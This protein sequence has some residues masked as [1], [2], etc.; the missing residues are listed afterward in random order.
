[1]SFV[2]D[3]AWELSNTPG[4]IGTASLP[5][6]VSS[7]CSDRNVFQRASD[8]A[9]RL[10]VEAGFRERLQRDELGLDT[11]TRGRLTRAGKR[12][13][14]LRIEEHIRTETSRDTIARGRATLG[15]ARLSFEFTSDDKNATF[16]LKGSC[17]SSCA[18]AP[19]LLVRVDAKRGQCTDERSRAGSKVRINLAALEIL[20]AKIS[21]GLAPL[22]LCHLLVGYLPEMHDEEW[23]IPERLTDAITCPPKTVVGSQWWRRHWWRRVTGEARRRR[24]K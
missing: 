11:A 10:A 5:A 13:A 4:V 21:S 12:L 7:D 18:H 1:M 3:L 6:L 14:R 15:A 23:E 20:E 19:V 24:R 9:A 17:R 22:H 8:V 16:I 2:D